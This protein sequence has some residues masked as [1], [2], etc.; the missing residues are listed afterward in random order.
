MIRLL[1]SFLIVFTLHFTAQSQTTDQETSS[2]IILILDGSGSMWGSIDNNTKIGIAKEVIASVLGK[3]DPD[4]AVGL[5]VYGHRHKGDCNDIETLIQ[6]AVGN[7]KEILRVLDG[8]NPTGKTPLANTALKVI[9]QLKRDKQRATLILIS[10][11]I[12]SCGGDLCMVVKAAK[13]AGVEFVLH[14]VG[15]ALGDS[16]KL[17]LECAAKEGNGM[18]LD[19]ENGAQ[20]SEA[21]EKTT[22]ATVENAT[23]TLSVKLTKNGRNHDGLIKIFKSGE[24]NYFTSRRTY[25][26]EKSNPALFSISPGTYDI[27]AAPLGTDAEA[28]TKKNVIITAEELK[29]I[30]IDFTAGKLSILTTG[31]GELWDCVV[32]IFK[33]GESQTAA[34]GR[35]YISSDSNPMIKELTPGMYTIKLSPMKIQGENINHEFKKIE[36]VPGSTTEVE[37]NYEY[38]EISVIGKNNGLLWDCVL[39]VNHGKKFLAGGR[40][41]DSPESKPSKYLLSPGTYNVLFKPHKIHGQNST[42]TVDKIIV[43]SK[44]KQEVVHDFKTGLLHLTVNHKS[45]LW[46]STISIYLNDVVVYSKRTGT[47]ESTNPRSIH[48]NPGIYTVKVL[49]LKLDAKP[50]EF[51]LDLKQGMVSDQL[52]E[53]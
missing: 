36:I 39:N 34:K 21:L 33:E 35:T 23:P 19:A 47:S 52:I 4:Q 8:I 26:G 16:D 51:K 48:L 37:H 9:N 42:F 15:F 17:A 40:T 14:I 12:E 2:S 45:E 22:A 7:H 49:P 20:L 1:I 53:F 18:Y 30:E 50:K 10:D 13:E 31:N 41:G 46:K 24:T 11:G 27:Q 44:S 29:E 32:N 28:I 3:M 5:E 25:T 6:P 38:G 43:D